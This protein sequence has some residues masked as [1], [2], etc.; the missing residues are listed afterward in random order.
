MLEHMRSKSTLTDVTLVCE[1]K[2][3]FNAHKNNL[4]QLEQ[5]IDANLYINSRITCMLKIVS[6]NIRNSDSIKCSRKFEIKIITKI[7]YMSFLS[8]VISSSWPWYQI[9]SHCNVSIWLLL[10]H[11]KV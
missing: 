6:K 3:M 10:P 4:E 1:D 5:F 11:V 9:I 7:N 2:T 8:F